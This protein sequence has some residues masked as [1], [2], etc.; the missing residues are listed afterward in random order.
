M[1]VVIDTNAL[2]PTLCTTH[3]FHVI[4]QAWAR[5]EF[6]WAL[7]TEAMLEYEEIARPRLGDLRWNHFTRILERVGRRHK[8]VIHIAPTFRFRTITHDAD[9]DKFADCAITAEADYIITEDRHFQALIGSGYK[10]RP[11]TPEE[12]LRR[13]LSGS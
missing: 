9:D 13:H 6:A 8:N 10:P 4:F 3:P 11:I 12:F 7:T 1:I 5:G 2:L